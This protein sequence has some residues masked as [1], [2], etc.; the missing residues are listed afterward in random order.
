MG[1]EEWE[2]VFCTG[3]E[4]TPDGKKVNCEPGKAT[5]PRG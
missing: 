2:G 1:W 3:N 5:D 4:D